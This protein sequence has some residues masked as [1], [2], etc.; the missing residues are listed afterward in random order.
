MAIPPNQDNWRR[1]PAVKYEDWEQTPDSVKYL[2]SSLWEQITNPNYQL[3]PLNNRVSLRD[4]LYVIRKRW[5]IIVFILAS[6]IIASVVFTYDSIPLYEAKSILLVGFGRGYISRA[7]DSALVISRDREAVIQAELQILHSRDLLASVVDVLGGP[8]V[9]YP[10]LVTELGPVTQQKLLEGA[11]S[12]FREHYSV[13]PVP[14]SD[15]IDIA[16]QHQNPEIAANAVNQIVHLFK[17]KHNEIFRGSQFID[18]LEKQVA[19]YQDELEHTETKL[20]SFLEK[21]KY[22]SPEEY[23]KSLLVKKQN[24]EVSINESKNQIA[25][26]KNKI[27]FLKRESRKKDYFSDPENERVVNDIKTKLLNLKLE[28]QRL[29]SKYREASPIVVEHRKQIKILENFLK[30]Q[31]VAIRSSS[32]YKEFQMGIVK[33]EAEL[34]FHEKRILELSDQLAQMNVELQELPKKQD[35]Y[36]HLIRR[37]DLNEEN[38]YSHLK[39][40]EKARVS[41]QA[42]HQDVGTVNVIQRAAVPSRSAPSGRKAKIA[43]GVLLGMT[44]GLGLAFFVE[45]VSSNRH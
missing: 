8:K 33:L 25:G 12:R 5:V 2:T 9:L 43:I 40:L 11:V 7:D 39:K 21:N 19:S 44:M 42:D 35:E 10:D 6:T 14:S 34:S 30:E 15:V 31:K 4:M 27:V 17:E 13:Q 37:R 16:F 24:L 20:K 3:E 41:E 22:S 23:G 29:L 26:L 38:Y 45:N 36:R 32:S 1:L 28:E 18:V